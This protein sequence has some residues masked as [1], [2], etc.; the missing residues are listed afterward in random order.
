MSLIKIEKHEDGVGDFIIQY[1]DSTIMQQIGG[2]FLT[3]FVQ[4]FSKEATLDFNP[5][6]YHNFTK[7]EKKCYPL[8]D[9]V[10]CNEKYQKE[11]RVIRTY[12]E[13]MGRLDYLL[14]KGDNIYAIEFKHSGKSYKGVP[15]P[16]KG[17]YNKKRDTL[18]RQTV[19]MVLGKEVTEG[20]KIIVIGIHFLV[21]LS[22]SKKEIRQFNSDNYHLITIRKEV[23]KQISYIEICEEKSNDISIGIPT[24]KA[25]WHL[26]KGLVYALDHRGHNN[27]D[28][29]A[30][31]PS[32]CYIGYIVEI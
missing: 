19:E 18:M 25:I 11:Y 1:S 20:K 17:C 27:P 29:K 6:H 16:K 21:F 24:F 10:F 5:D 14:L 8:I 4:D 13:N 28:K 2:K 30:I 7:S 12:L 9:R 22:R 31:Y 15:L 32:L 3:K 23:E 26:H